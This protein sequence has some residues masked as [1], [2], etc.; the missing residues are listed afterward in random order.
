MLASST[1]ALLLVFILSTA[2]ASMSAVG[3]PRSS[4]GMWA[5]AR[6][7]WHLSPC[8]AA[9][10]G[11]EFRTQSELLRRTRVGRSPHDFQ[12]N[13]SEFTRNQLSEDDKEKVTVSAEVA[14]DTLHRTFLAAPWRPTGL[15]IVLTSSPSVS[16]MNFSGWAVRL[17]F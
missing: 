9:V 14:V 11:Q 6:R 4:G 12:W 17:S 2:G 15:G 13:V 7:P 3:H 16:S 5:M 10:A 1:T 8:V